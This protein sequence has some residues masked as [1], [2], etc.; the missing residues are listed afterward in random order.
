MCARNV[1]NIK[2]KFF[3]VSIPVTVFVIAF[4]FTFKFYLQRPSLDNFRRNIRKKDL[5]SF[6]DLLRAC[7]II[8][9]YASLNHVYNGILSLFLTKII[10]NS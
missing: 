2:L 4:Y 10:K 5:T 9:T 6:I 7:A 3:A 8:V 1:I